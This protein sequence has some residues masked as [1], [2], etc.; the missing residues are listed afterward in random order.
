MCVCGVCAVIKSSP[1]S[2]ANRPSRR[3]V[4]QDGSGCVSLATFVFRRSGALGSQFGRD[5]F[6]SLLATRLAWWRFSS[7]ASKQSCQ[8]AYSPPRPLTPPE[9]L[10]D[11]ADAHS[12][13]PGR[14]R[15]QM[16][17]PA[18]NYR[19]SI[20]PAT[21]LPPCRAANRQPHW[22]LQRPR[23]WPAGA[24]AS[25]NL[26]KFATRKVN[27]LSHARGS[28]GAGCCKW[29]WEPSGKR[30]RNPAGRAAGTQVQV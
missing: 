13:V 24:L 5:C 3:S 30:M 26:T 7:A 23:R 2:L 12:L 19:S 9:R 10:L 21:K 17:G 14:P 4:G 16:G 22:R 18:A 20:G 15:C 27:R 25:A 11:P 8:R 6:W 1:N 29:K 28:G